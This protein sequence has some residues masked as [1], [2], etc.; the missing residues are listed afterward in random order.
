VRDVCIR[1]EGSNLIIVRLNGGLGNQLFQYSAA[2][3]LAKKNQ[4]QF[5][6]DLS[7]YDKQYGKRNTVRSPDLLHF[8]IS[9][10]IANPQESYKLRNPKGQVSRITRFMRQKMFKQYYSDWHPQLLE[11]TGDIYLEGY[12]QCEKYF[13]SYYSELDLDL[14]LRAEYAGEIAEWERRLSTIS[15]PVSLHVRRGDYVSD[16]KASAVHN[17]CTVGYYLRAIEEMK[18]RVDNA[19]LVVFSDD[20]DW[21]HNNLKLGDSAIYVSGSKNKKGAS[22]LASQELIIMSRCAHHIISNSSFSWWGAYLNKRNDKVVL[23]PS[24][25]NRSMIDN[26]KNILPESWIR[27][28]IG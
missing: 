15:N 7:A 4:D 13:K 24:L 27:I 17:I 18:K 11:K 25:W 23:A 16:L 10:L 19:T 21:V 9:S 3:G 22:L 12:F 1:E 8:S 20:I 14:N 2:Y 26:H 28:Q 6:I 5:K